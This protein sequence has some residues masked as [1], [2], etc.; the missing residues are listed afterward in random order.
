MSA[1]T[2]H[3]VDSLNKYFISDESSAATGAESDDPVDCISG[4]GEIVL[5]DS[6]KDCQTGKLK[7]I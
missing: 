5:Q 4:V 3:L 2:Q 1:T 6:N 7:I